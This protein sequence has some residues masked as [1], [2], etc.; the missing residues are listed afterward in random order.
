MLEMTVVTLNFWK[1][2][3][4]AHFWKTDHSNKQKGNGQSFQHLQNMLR[5][6]EWLQRKLFLYLLG[7][8][9]IYFSGYLFYS[10]TFPS[11]SFLFFFSGLLFFIILH[12][13]SETK[14]KKSLWSVPA[15]YKNISLIAFSSSYLFLFEEFDH[16]LYIPAQHEIFNSSCFILGQTTKQSSLSTV[17]RFV[18]SS[19]IVWFDSIFS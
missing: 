7:H 6:H 10:S 18:N 11:V 12:D 16:E 15:K 3:W 19:N 5:F 17:C 2:S 1:T 13:I 4:N 9:S 8:L 14:L